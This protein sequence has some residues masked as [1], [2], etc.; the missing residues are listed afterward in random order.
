MAA[1]QVATAPSSQLLVFA[2]DVGWRYRRSCAQPS[3]ATNDR[4]DRGSRDVVASVERALAAAAFPGL[5]SAYLFGSYSLG[6]AH[7]ESDVDIG[8]L[9]RHAK[10]PTARERFEARLLLI[11][12]LQ[13]AVG[14]EVDLV[15]LN[16]APPPLARRIVTAGR[17]VFDA[18]PGADHAFVRDVQLRAADLAPFLR[19]TRQRKLAAILR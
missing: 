6:R 18:D 13:R 7:A 17:R 16:D 1:L 12:E 4:M 2:P 19:W 3:C 8:V 15:I 5:V 14:R 10:Y 9:L 11:A